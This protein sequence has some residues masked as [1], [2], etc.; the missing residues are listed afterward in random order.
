MD[1]NGETHQK[2]DMP[3][4]PSR[5]L[6]EGISVSNFPDLFLINFM[7]NWRLLPRQTFGLKVVMPHEIQLFAESCTPGYWMR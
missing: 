2:G 4:L 1:S 5:A 7:D 3:F 6:P